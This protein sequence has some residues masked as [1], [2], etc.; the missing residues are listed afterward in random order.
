MNLEPE[1]VKEIVDGAENIIAGEGTASGENRCSDA[2]CEA[3]K[4]LKGAKRLLVC[5]A[6]GPEIALAE[7]SGAAAA[8]E[9]A[10]D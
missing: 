6:S 4:K 8:V 5:V 3:A 2:A 1:D 10:A 7:M 9:K